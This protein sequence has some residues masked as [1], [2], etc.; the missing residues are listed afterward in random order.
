[1]NKRP[2]DCEFTPSEPDTMEMLFNILDGVRRYGRIVT[3]AN[4]RR[5]GMMLPKGQEEFSWSPKFEYP[6][7]SD[8]DDWRW[9]RPLVREV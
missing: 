9:L 5:A 1:M 6:P 8:H 7:L 3:R 4:L 2:E